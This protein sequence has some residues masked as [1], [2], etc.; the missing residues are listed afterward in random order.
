MI[1]LRLT[2]SADRN[3]VQSSM[4]DDLGSLSGLL[5]S[6][7]TGEG[8]I[9]GEAMPIPS[10]VRFHKAKNKPQGNDPAMPQAWQ[11]TTRP[12]STLY[13]QALANWRCQ[14]MSTKIK[15]GKSK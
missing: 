13:A 7:R 12:D 14:S 5:P 6:L 8:L 9:V 10:R 4:P 3:K 1:S 11:Q 15:K 2:N